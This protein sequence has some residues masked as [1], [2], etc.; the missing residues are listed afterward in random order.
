MKL[1]L[2]LVTFVVWLALVLAAAAAAVIYGAPHLKPATDF[3]NKMA[4][5]YAFLNAIKQSPDFPSQVW[6]AGLGGGIV[7][8]LFAKVTG[9]CCRR[10]ADVEEELPPE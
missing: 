3:I 5:D 4:G 6:A 9:L 1:V 10:R 2:V 8:Y 7:S